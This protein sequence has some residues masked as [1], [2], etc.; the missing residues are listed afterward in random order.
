M[1]WR[2]MKQWFLCSMQGIKKLS[3]QMAGQIRERNKLIG[4]L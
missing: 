3:R 1:Y 4:L 2:S